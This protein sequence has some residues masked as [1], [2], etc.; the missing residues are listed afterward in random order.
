MLT[1]ME[2]ERILQDKYPE[3]G[4]KVERFN[5]HYRIYS[6]KEIIGDHTEINKFVNNIIK[7]IPEYDVMF[8]KIDNYKGNEILLF[9][10]ITASL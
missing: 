10:A 4:F 7:N 2:I 9:I 5:N 6:T 3:F 8:Y 1:Q